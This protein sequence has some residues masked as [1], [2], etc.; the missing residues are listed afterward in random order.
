MMKKETARFWKTILIAIAM[1][2]VVDVSVGVVAD[3]LMDKLPDFSGDLAKDNYRLHRVETDVVIIG[4]S[5]GC[6][7]YVSQ[8]LA[9]SIDACLGKH[10]SLY[11][12]SISAKRANSNSCAAEVLISRYRPQLVIYDIFE[13]VLYDDRVDDIEFSAPFYWKDTIVRRYLD[14]IGLKERLLM[15]S[16]LYR[17]NA[18]LFR[19]VSS[20][21]TPEAPS[22][23]YEPL[24]GTKIGRA[25]YND[26][27]E[28]SMPTLELDPYTLNNFETVLRKYSSE[29]IPLVVVC[30]PKFRPQDNNK[31]VAALCEKYGIPFIDFSDTPYFNDH[32]ELFYDTQHLND[33]G[34]HVFTALFFEQ[35]KPYLPK[36]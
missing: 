18:K 6:Y 31:R 15:K 14:N 25:K 29:K 33:D 4:S 23:G 21:F 9:D 34:A 36:P 5:R 3:G 16:S 35:L 20:I 17:Y 27:E 22:D 8:Q 10:L 28:D 26:D 11:N 12:A 13:E 32:P 30:S 7:H 1:L 24:R 2:V 19:I